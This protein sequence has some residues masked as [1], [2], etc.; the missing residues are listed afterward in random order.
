MIDLICLIHFLY[1]MAFIVIFFLLQV[2]NK[3]HQSN[4]IIMNINAVII[5]S[6]QQNINTF[7]QA[8]L[9]FDRSGFGC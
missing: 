5:L 3:D 8:F 2:Q 1:I 6:H 7:D 4:Q 9:V